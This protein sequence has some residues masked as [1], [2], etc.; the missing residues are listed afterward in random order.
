MIN[1]VWIQNYRNFTEATINCDEGAHVFLLGQNNQGKTNFLES[2]HA[3][4]HLKGPEQSDISQLVKEGAD[5]SNL[6]V[7]FTTNGEQNR[8]YIQLFSDKT[9]SVS[10]NSEPL[11][12]YRS[13]LS[14][15]PVYHVCADTIRAFQGAADGRRRLL[16]QFL[17]Q[18]NGEYHTLW[19]EYQK[20][21]K[22]KN[23]LL[24][25]ISA[26]SPVLQV[27]NQQ[28]VDL[29]SKIIP[30]RIKCLRDV[31][32]VLSTLVPLFPSFE[33]KS[34]DIQYQSKFVVE[35]SESYRESLALCLAQ[36]MQKEL[37]AGIS[38]YGPHR[39]D[40]MVYVNELPIQGRWSRGVN[41]IMA[42]LLI[43]SMILIRNDEERRPVLLVDDA[44]AEVDDTF[45][46]V[47]IPLL[48]QYTQVFYATTLVEDRHFFLDPTVSMRVSSGTLQPLEAKDL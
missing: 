3:L 39:D 48:Q 27:I 32:D 45:K 12:S 46:S 20:L 6:A 15:L 25:T 16:N 29:S 34:L 44:F 42:I 28:L 4:S 23:T 36:N 37:Q 8:L 30:L 19:K 41:R 18:E 33:Y 35:S 9:K 24:K 1:K 22:Q 31:K 43:L 11:K 5:H 47:I 14:S 10:L 7:D 26:P 40:F 2:I 17:S 38:L 21:I 13:L